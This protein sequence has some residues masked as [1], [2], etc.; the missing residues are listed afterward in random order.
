MK[1]WSSAGNLLKAAFLRAPELSVCMKSS[2]RQETGVADWVPPGQ[3]KGL[4]VK[5]GICGLGTGMPS[6]CAEV[7]SGKSKHRGNLAR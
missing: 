5:V 7:R 3:A 6:K 1:E 4:K 2:R